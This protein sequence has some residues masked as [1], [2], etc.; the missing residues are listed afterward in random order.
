MHSHC[1]FGIMGEATLEKDEQRLLMCVTISMGIWQN[2]ELRSSHHIQT[3]ST[4]R[5]QRQA[6]DTQE[7][8][9]MAIFL[10][11]ERRPYTPELLCYCKGTYDLFGFTV[12]LGKELCPDDFF[13]FCDI[14]V[15][16]FFCVPFQFLYIPIHI[17]YKAGFTMDT[18][19]LGFCLFF[20]CV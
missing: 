3:Y 15:L 2:T 8:T 19:T 11:Q 7:L 20:V 13:R 12:S 9:K 18:K 1:V 16:I 5:T 17:F 14:A 6:W 4:N 10:N